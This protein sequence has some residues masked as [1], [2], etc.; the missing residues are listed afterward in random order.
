MR[1]HSYWTWLKYI[2][3]FI[4]TSNNYMTTFQKFDKCNKRK[5]I[6]LHIAN[7]FICVD[8]RN[9]QQKNII[10]DL[11]SNVTKIIRISMKN[12]LDNDSKN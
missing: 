6:R 10:D 4:K 8:R 12:M 2:N 7:L 9:I 1:P 5:F 11:Y 3:N